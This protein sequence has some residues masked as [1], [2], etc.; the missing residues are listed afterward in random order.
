MNPRRL[1]SRYLLHNQLG[2]GAMGVVWRGQDLDTGTEVAVKL[3][4][5]EYTADPAFVARFVGERNALVRFRH[6]NVVALRDMI[7]EGDRL[8]LVMELVTGGDLNAF[9]ERNGGTLSA[10]V[11]ARL[12]AQ[13]FDGLAAAHGASIVHRDLKPAN[14]LLEGG[15]V[16]LADFGISRI[17]GGAKVTSAGIVMG[18]VAYLA[19]ELIKG[20]EP[21]AAGDVYA[22]GITLYE[23]LSGAVPFDGHVAAVMNAHV[24]TAPER[25]AG[26]PDR[27]WDLIAACLSKD[28]SARPTAAH[29]SGALSALAATSLPSAPTTVDLAPGRA[30]MTTVDLAPGRPPVTTVDLAPGRA[31]MMPGPPQP[32]PGPPGPAAGS[33]QPAAGPAAGSPGPAAGVPAIPPPRRRSRMTQFI[34]AIAVFA[35]AVAGGI[36]YALE[37]GK[38]PA[39]ASLQRNG[40]AAPTAGQTTD[41]GGAT[42]AP[43]ASGGTHPSGTPGTRPAGASPAPDT[44]PGSGQPTPATSSPGSKPTKPAPSTPAPKSSSPKAP[45]PSTSPPSSPSSSPPANVP[46]QCGVFVGTTLR[47]GVAANGSLQACA[48]VNAGVLQ[49]KGTLNGADVYPKAALRLVI[50]NDAGTVVAAETSAY[51]TTAS[52][53]FEMNLTNIPHGLLGV[54]PSWTIAGIRQS[55]GESRS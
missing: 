16:K 33:P 9:R 35:A 8:A 13:I 41:P 46:W 7:V 18:T 19:P 5:S 12:G 23:L 2:Q 10:A 51:C 54:V 49:I 32:P 1:G 55:F 34:V 24:N 26:V 45:G 52:C 11:T 44:V 31:P 36:T 14:V 53:T 6:P 21:A 3:L 4:R 29:L 27:L 37:S 38:G 39:S 50:K 40:G 22:V 20:E 28:A 17:A 48:R 15:Q 43:G 30:S 42:A 47:S 25:I